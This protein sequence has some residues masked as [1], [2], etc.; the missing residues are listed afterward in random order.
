M[1]MI[2][3]PT[4][5]VM[6]SSRAEA[7]II[8]KDMQKES[9]IT[10]AWHMQTSFEPHLYAIS[11]GKDRFSAELIK[12]SRCFAVN[13]IPYELSQ[14]AIF[15]GTHTGRHMDKF[16]EAGLEKKECEKIDCP[17]IGEALAWMECEVTD[18]HE[19]GDHLIFIG[20][21]VY[22]Q[23]ARVGKRL[24]LKDQLAFTTTVE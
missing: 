6:V 22:E 8:G 1:S 10:V 20:E 14:K 2:N 23:Q 11:I 4:Q 17:R 18:I 21:V 19:S 12:R 24:F 16:S 3:H 9:I 13:F 15:L 7:N 5:A